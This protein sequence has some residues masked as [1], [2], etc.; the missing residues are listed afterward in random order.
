MTSPIICQCDG[1]AAVATDGKKPRAPR[2]LN[3]MPQAS[4]VELNDMSLGCVST[5]SSA[6]RPMNRGY[7]RSL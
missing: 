7:V 2:E 3:A 1:R 4:Q 6:S 5:P